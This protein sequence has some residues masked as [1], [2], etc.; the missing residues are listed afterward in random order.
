MQSLPQHF[1]PVLIFMLPPSTPTRRSFLKT[2]A[3]LGA[4]STI[5][6]LTK[7]ATTAKPAPFKLSLAQW[8]L[9]RRFRRLE[10]AEPLDNLEFARTARTLGFDGI[11]ATCPK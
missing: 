1:R 9:N 2:A 3:A 7:A 4:L 11:P 8:S 5:P 6:A 10:G